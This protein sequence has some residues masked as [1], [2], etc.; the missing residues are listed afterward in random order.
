[1][2]SADKEPLGCT[3]C[4]KCK[5]PF[6]EFTEE[7]QHDWFFRMRQVKEGSPGQEWQDMN[8]P[9]HQRVHRFPVLMESWCPECG[10]VELARIEK[11]G[12]EQHGCPTHDL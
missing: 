12:G 5:I 9:V 11:E 4:F 7:G 1:M 3:L 2:S 8:C 10:K 6:D